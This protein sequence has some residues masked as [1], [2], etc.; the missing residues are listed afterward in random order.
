MRVSNRLV[1]SAACLVLDEYEMSM[2][3]QKLM[4]SLGQDAP[5]GKPVLEINPDHALL[6]RLEAAAGDEA[7]VGDYARL[8][9]D[10]AMLAE[11]GALDDP[12]TFIARMNRLLAG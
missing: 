9:F 5:A 2:Q 3:M 8:L 1:D 6:K 11:T 4:K 10:Q 12:A 7:L